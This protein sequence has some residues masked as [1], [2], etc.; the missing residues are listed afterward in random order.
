MK[1]SLVTL[2]FTVCFPTLL[3]GWGQP[4]HAIT[5]AALETLP[6]WQKELLGVE[7]KALLQ[8]K[9]ADLEEELH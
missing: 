4:H 1:H 7:L 9:M 3:F 6:G 2:L 8:E 5:R